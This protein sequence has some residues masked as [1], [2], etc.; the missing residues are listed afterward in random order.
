MVSFGTNIVPT[1]TMAPKKMV[2]YFKRGK[3]KS[4]APSFR[5]IDE[6]TDN[7]SDPAYVPLNPRVSRAAPRSTP[8]KADLASLRTD[9]DVI[10]DA[11]SVETQ[12]AP[13][14]LADDTVLE[15]LFSGTAEEGPAPTHAKGK[16][17]QSHRTE[18]EK[19]HK[20]TAS[21]EEGG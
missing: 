4:F 7:D 19:A 17:H 16:R 12:A 11:P 15:A 9:V 3:S 8:R 21:A 6:D 18:E 20:M 2:T 14:A 5:L 10:L 13:T 1:G